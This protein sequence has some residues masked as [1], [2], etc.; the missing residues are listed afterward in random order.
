MEGA[1]V[2][3]DLLNGEAGGM[4]AVNLDLASESRS[5]FHISQAPICHG[6]EPCT[7]LVSK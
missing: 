2:P 3:A 4:L 6:D 1:R 7:V 5:V